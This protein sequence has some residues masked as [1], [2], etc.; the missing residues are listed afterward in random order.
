MAYTNAEKALVIA[1]VDRWGFTSGLQFLASEHD[2]NPS[3][4]TVC[5]WRN[6]GFPVT[7]AALEELERI[8]GQRKSKW[9]ASWDALREQGF[10]AVGRAFDD[11]R[12]L[13]AQQGSFSLGIATDKLFGSPKTGTPVVGNAQTV[14]MQVVTSAAVPGSRDEPI[15]LP[16]EVIE[17]KSREVE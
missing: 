17:G 3:E 6:E 9:M 1:A 10:A 14:I 4:S 13:A 11:D 8:E 12:M 5:V 15:S 2:L 16:G 7:D